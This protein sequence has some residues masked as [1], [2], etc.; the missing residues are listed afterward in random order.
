MP[1]V[2]E[3]PGL[4]TGRELFR[5]GHLRG[6]PAAAGHPDAPRGRAS[7]RFNVIP[8]ESLDRISRDQ[9]DIA[10][11][12]KRMSGALAMPPI[13]S[14]TTSPHQTDDQPGPVGVA[15]ICDRSGKLL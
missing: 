3:A 14:P 9:E 7:E 2:R 8:A 15:N 10:G 12:Y 13:S 4:A 11:V 5:P 1:R 6:Q